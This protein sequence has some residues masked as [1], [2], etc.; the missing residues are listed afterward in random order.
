MNRDRVAKW[1]ARIIT[2][3]NVTRLQSWLKYMI[4]FRHEYKNE[5]TTLTYD[6]PKTVVFMIDGKTLHG[7]MSDRLRGLFSVYYYC[8]KKNLEFKVA[9]TH[10]FKLQDYLIPAGKDW[11]ANETDLSH[12]KRNV[13]FRFFNNY[14][15]MS[16]NETEYFDI[17]DTKKPI[18]H[19]YSCIT[20]KEEL[21]AE[22]FNELFKPAPLLQKSIDKCLQEIGGKYISLTFR[23]IGLLG[24]FK[25]DLRWN[26]ELSRLEK[27]R[28][29]GKCLACLD[30]LH[31]K[32]PEYKRILVTAD[33]PI[34]LDIVSKIPYVYVMPG[35][36][37]NMDFVNDS[38][39]E[40]HLKSFIDF[41]M[42]SKAEKCYVYHY[43]QMFKF[44]KFAKTAA[45]VGGKELIT[46]SE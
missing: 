3:K 4:I 42:I 41:I 44:T 40:L 11:V 39:Y 37:V 15:Q 1:L 25:D 33:S 22:F 36:V 2:K 32:Y 9:W 43:A 27:N 24:D 46:V 38:N 7:G 17:L 26:V 28:Y 20:I 5:F 12:N 29:I 13:A 21:Y 31:R 30:C 6:R 16:N 19:V 35:K 10:P 14:T 8:K 18:E 23:F 34:F 45:L